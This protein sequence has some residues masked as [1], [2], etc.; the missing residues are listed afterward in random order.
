MGA[1]VPDSMALYAEVV[2]SCASKAHLLPACF[3]HYELL[4]EAHASMAYLPLLLDNNHE[5]PLL[6]ANN[7][8]IVKMNPGTHTKIKDTRKLPNP[9]RPKLAP[10][11][12]KEKRSQ[13]T[14]PIVHEEALSGM[15][16]VVLFVMY[17][18]LMRVLR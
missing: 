12:I 1:S 13:N 11:S 10:N 7:I 4:C 8:R 18:L 5:L 16:M 2:I 3:A 15:S 17:S 9:P 14:D 6:I